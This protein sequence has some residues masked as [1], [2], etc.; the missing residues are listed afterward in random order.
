MARFFVSN[1]RPRWRRPLALALLVFFAFVN[2]HPAAVLGAPPP[3]SAYRL[4]AEDEA[5]LEDLSRRSFQF[6]WEQANPETGLVLDRS[7]TDGTPSSEN[8]R[9]VASIASTGFG[10]SALCIAAERG[11]VA[12]N[13]ARERVRTTL[14]F[15]ADRVFNE[16]GWFYHWM[17]ART[18]ERVWRSEISSI[19]TALLL[20]GVLV[21]RQ[22]FRGDAEIVRLATKIYERVDFRWMLDGHP[23]LL[24]HGSRPETGFI[25]NRWDTY[26]EQMSLLLLGVGSPTH[27]L[28]PASWRAWSRKWITYG[29]HTYMHAHP[30]L[31]IHQYSHAWVDFRGWREKLVSARGLLRELGDGDAR[32]PPVLP[33]PRAGVP[34]LHREHLGHHGFGQRARLRGVGRAAAPPAHRRHGRAV[35][36]GRLAD[37]HAGHRRPGPARDARA[38]SANASTVATASPTPSTR[39]TAGSTRT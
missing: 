14:R 9:Y 4:T 28:P 8:H 7:R 21:A 38:S 32:A 1:S 20:G 18:G 24:S 31:F 37:V 13:E 33:R 15:F 29:G 19:D 12:K 17:D 36:R 26:S 11:W 2:L 39:T 23:T 35:R 25:R 6:F 3:Q 22:Y 34:R 27:P 30:P 5:F 10:L 16:H